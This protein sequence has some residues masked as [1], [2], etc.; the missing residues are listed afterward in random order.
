MKTYFF[1]SFALLWNYYGSLKSHCDKVTA[2]LVSTAYGQRSLIISLDSEKRVLP[3]FIHRYLQ[4]HN[5]IKPILS[6]F[7]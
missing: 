2:L 4:F 3:A 5:L 7:Q 6:P 1:F